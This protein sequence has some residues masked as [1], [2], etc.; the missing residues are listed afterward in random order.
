MK[1]IIALILTLCC[2]FSF[3]ACGNDETASDGIAE[4]TAMYAVSAPTKVATTYSV[5]LGN[6]NVSGTSVL[7]AGTLN[8]GSSATVLVYD[9][10]ELDTISNGAGE[11]ITPISTKSSGSREFVEGKGERVDGGSWDPNGFN[12]APTAGSLGISLSKETVKNPT[13]S[14]N[15]KTHTLSFTVE[16]ANTGAVFGPDYEIF[17]DATVVITADGA[18]IT[19]ITVSY[20]IPI[21]PEDEDEELVYPDAEVS[22][23]T[24]YTYVLER[25]TLTK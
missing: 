8:D 23:S 9:Y 6:V 16:E 4:F 15:G 7:T 12:F 25:V 24:Q 10:S 11:V 5:K 1:K 20:K 22:I 18:V 3:A 19:G 14:V 17:G 2:V 21:V 13:Y